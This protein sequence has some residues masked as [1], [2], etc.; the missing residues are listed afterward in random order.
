MK[1]MEH[2]ICKYCGE[3]FLTGSNDPN[4]CDQC[5]DNIYTTALEES[6]VECPECGSTDITGVEYEGYVCRSCKHG[7][8]VDDKAVN[9]DLND[10]PLGLKI[11]SII[12][13][14]F[15]IPFCIYGIWVYLV[16]L[17][18]VPTILLLVSIAIFIFLIIKGLIEA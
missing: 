5:A 15:G 12:A 13:L 9:R 2:K 4:I 10:M 8:S 1:V 16:I 6:L 18:F 3:L 14:I 17:G 11:R 7:W